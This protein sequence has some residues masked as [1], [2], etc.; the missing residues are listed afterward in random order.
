MIIDSH[1]HIG[2]KNSLFE[3][4]ES[5]VLYAMQT[6]NIDRAIV[7]N[8]DSVEFD[9]SHV[10]LPK[11]E[12]VSQ[13]NSAVRMINFARNHTPGIYAAIWLKPNT[14]RLEKS[15]AEL[16]KRNL[17]IVKAIKVHPFYSALRFNDIK[18][19]EY[20]ELAENLNLPVI[21]HTAN[22]EFSNPELV[23]DM[24]KK[25]PSVKFIMAHLELNSDNRRATE[26]CAR[27]PNLLADTAWVSITN[28]ISFIQH[29]GGEKLLFGSD[30]PIDGKDTYLKNKAGNR[31]IY[32]D[33]F[34]ELE[35]FI[36]PAEYE[37]VMYK[38]ALRIFNIS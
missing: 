20:I 37:N 28:A 14:E 34:Y 38:N 22:D 17:D 23:F 6:Y 9:P 5:D 12:Q 25:Y 27:L 31:S 18:M 19:N 10:I 26:L 35:K 7:S 11:E 2:G 3:M 16:L 32:Q 4:K 15:F 8:A 13:Y 29:C 1:M 21:V 36:S 24:A 30:A 33:Y